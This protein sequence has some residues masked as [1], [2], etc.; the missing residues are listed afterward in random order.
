M[1]EERCGSML[2][3]ACSD[4]LTGHSTLRNS[5]AQPANRACSSIPVLA[6]R[7]EPI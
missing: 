1:L 3:E 5:A 2:Q 6:E 4:K 7:A